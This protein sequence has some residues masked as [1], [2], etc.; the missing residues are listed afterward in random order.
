MVYTQANTCSAV[1]HL[2][3]LVLNIFICFKIHVLDLS[4]HHILKI[5]DCGDARNSASIVEIC[6][7]PSFYEV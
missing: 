5:I 4:T 7:V 1:Q 6:A 2:N 3:V